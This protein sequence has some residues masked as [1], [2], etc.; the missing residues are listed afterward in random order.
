MRKALIAANWKCHGSSAMVD[1]YAAVL[2]HSAKAET[3]VFPPTVFVAR[4]ATCAVQ[5]SGCGVQD[6]GVAESGAH[7][8][9]VSAA[10]VR[11]VG[12][13]WA[14]VGH[15]ERR[16]NQLESDALVAAKFAAALRAGLRPILCI[17]ETE[18]QRDR[19]EAMTVVEQQLRS[20]LADI[21][22]SQI[23]LSAIAYEPIWA[24]G[25][26]RTATPQQAQDMHE[27]IRAVV[28][29]LDVD[30]AKATRII[31]GGSVNADNA[32]ALFAQTDIDGALVGG[33][34]LQLDTFTRIIAA[35]A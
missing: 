35:A 23:A 26:G 7:T 24:I 27:G 22:P 6:L 20:A 28:H 10:M 25:T 19:G 9:E 21:D 2:A 14:I 8:G 16:Q 32:A 17:G 4:Y 31:Y 11:E 1:E 5:R 12:G 18:Q 29:S 3:V 34:S 30:A 15:S 13:R 33:A